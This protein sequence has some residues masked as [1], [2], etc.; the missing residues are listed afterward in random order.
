[1]NTARMRAVNQMTTDAICVLRYNGC[2]VAISFSPI[3][4]ID[5]AVNISLLGL[6]H[7]NRFVFI[8]R[9]IVCIEHFCKVC[10]KKIIILLNQRI[11]HNIIHQCIMGK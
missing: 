1:M 8:G 11:N 6:S 4:I 3:P 9:I 5:Y 10:A 7:P 2:Y